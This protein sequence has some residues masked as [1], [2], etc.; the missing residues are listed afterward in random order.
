MLAVG[1]TECDDVYDHLH[2]V[3]PTSSLARRPLVG[4]VLM[5]YGYLRDGWITMIQAC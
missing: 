3:G 2:E 4:K 1:C 5:T